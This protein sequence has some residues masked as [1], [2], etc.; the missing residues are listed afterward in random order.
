MPFIARPAAGQI[1]D[2]A[3]GTLVADA[4]VMRFTTAAQ[5]S[6]QLTA[7]VTGQLTAL[8]TAPGA[9]DYWTGT[10]WAP[11]TRELAYNQVTANTTIT[12]TTLGVAQLVVPG[13]ARTYDAAPII[14]EINSPNV[15]TPAVASGA[16]HLVLTD[17]SAPIAELVQLAATSQISAPVHARL[18]LTPTAGSHTYQVFA[19]VSPSGT[20]VVGAGAGTAGAWAPTYLRISRA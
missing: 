9:L 19:W 13:T 2:P 1:I 14:A 8:D 4:V 3:W 11:A 20:G 17:G 16:I 12:N 18:R 6:S 7:P 10:A 5:R 15:L